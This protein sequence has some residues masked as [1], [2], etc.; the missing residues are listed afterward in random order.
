MRKF[1]LKKVLVI[2][3][4]AALLGIPLGDLGVPSHGWG[5]GAVHA[6]ACTDDPVWGCG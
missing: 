2:T 4:L 5:S 6:E 1:S 3:L